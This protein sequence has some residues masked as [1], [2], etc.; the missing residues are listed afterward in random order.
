MKLVLLSGIKGSGIDSIVTELAKHRFQTFEANT[1]DL[2]DSRLEFANLVRLN[3]DMVIV[4]EPKKLM[5]LLRM[6]YKT[7][8]NIKSSIQLA[9]V[10][11]D[12]SV[13]SRISIISQE[14]GLDID[15]PSI[16]D[17]LMANKTEKIDLGE[18]DDKTK[19]LLQNIYGVSRSN[20]LTLYSY[21]DDIYECFNGR[22]LE[23]MVEYI[24]NRI[25]KDM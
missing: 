24:T 2:K 3:K 23:T 14:L 20:K 17:I 19:T 15:D 8:T 12:L 1:M 22:S 4:Y 5:S 9:I 13:K 11:L 16:S 25:R 7:H 21:T 6:V 10:N 18:L